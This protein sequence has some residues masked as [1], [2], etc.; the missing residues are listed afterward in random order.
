MR[1]RYVEVA[2]A[3][4]AQNSVDLLVKMAKLDPNGLTARYYAAVMLGADK[5]IASGQ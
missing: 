3:L 4:T 2:Q 5:A 1:K